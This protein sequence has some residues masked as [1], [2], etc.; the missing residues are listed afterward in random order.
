MAINIADR[1]RSPSI[2][3]NRTALSDSSA[4]KFSIICWE[5]SQLIGPIVLSPRLRS[6]SELTE[7][8]MSSE[9][10]CQSVGAATSLNIYTMIIYKDWLYYPYYDML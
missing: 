6:D 4:G 1:D 7:V 8:I 2:R 9:Y 5:K 10:L 3:Y